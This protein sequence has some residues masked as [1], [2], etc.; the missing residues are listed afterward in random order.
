MRQVL[1]DY[2][3]DFMTCS[4]LLVMV[5]V[6]IFTLVAFARYVVWCFTFWFNLV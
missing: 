6:S 3:D 4:L 1:K 5:G 2:M